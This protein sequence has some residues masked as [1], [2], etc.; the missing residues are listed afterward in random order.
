MRKFL[1]K[2]WA[3][4]HY[5]SFE[6]KADDIDGLIFPGGFGTLDGDNIAN[7]ASAFNYLKTQFD[8][9]FVI[10]H[11]DTIKDFMDYLLPVNVEDNGFSKVVYN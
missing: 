10:T 4:D 1:V 2:I 6:V 7:M 3:Y 11:L 9:I 5:A 8:L